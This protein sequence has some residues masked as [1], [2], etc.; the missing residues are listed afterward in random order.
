MREA[1]AYLR[2]DAK[3]PGERGVLVIYCCITNHP[4]LNALKQPHSLTI[5]GLTGLSW[6]TRGCVTCRF[7]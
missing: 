2:A 4:K 6:F 3:Q 1:S 5:L 7:D